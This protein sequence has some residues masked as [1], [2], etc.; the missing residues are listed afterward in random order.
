MRSKRPALL[1]LDMVGGWHG[2]GA[3]MIHAVISQGTSLAPPASHMVCATTQ[4]P[5][6]W[7]RIDYSSTLYAPV[8]QDMVIR[9]VRGL[10]LCLTSSIVTLIHSRCWCSL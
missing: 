3:G 4:L 9:T 8:A 7:G 6:V 10:D 5:L 1:C 2:L